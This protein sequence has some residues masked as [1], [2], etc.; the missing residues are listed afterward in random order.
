MYLRQLS[1]GQ[2]IFP[3]K[4]VQFFQ[5][6]V[7]GLSVASKVYFECYEGKGSLDDCYFT[8]FVGISDLNLLSFL[9]KP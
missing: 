9:V 3:R 8:P 7:L 2:L 1:E 4:I 6:N 5:Y